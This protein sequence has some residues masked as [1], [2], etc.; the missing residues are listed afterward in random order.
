MKKNILIYASYVIDL[1]LIVQ[2][3]RLNKAISTAGKPYVVKRGGY[4]VGVRSRAGKGEVEKIVKD[5]FG[6]FA[7][8]F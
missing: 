7:K 1:D 8:V 2:C 3:L 4:A 5:R 6:S